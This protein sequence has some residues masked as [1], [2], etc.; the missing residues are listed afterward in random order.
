[1]MAVNV[2][3]SPSI[4]ENPEVKYSKIFRLY[5][6]NYTASLEREC[7]S[8][9]K[10]GFELTDKH[11]W[12]YAYR[13]HEHYHNYLSAVIHENAC[14]KDLTDSNY[15]TTIRDLTVSL[16]D[17]L[18]R[19]YNRETVPV[20]KFIVMTQR[21]LTSKPK[22]QG[23]ASKARNL[24]KF[25]AR[26]NLEAETKRLSQIL[27]VETPDTISPETHDVRES[28]TE[29]EISLEGLHIGETPREERN[30]ND[31][32]YSA[33]GARVTSWCS[34]YK[35]PVYPQ[36]RKKVDG[37]PPHKHGMIP[38]VIYV[39][40]YTNS[41]SQ[42]SSSSRFTEHTDNIMCHQWRN[43]WFTNH[44]P[45]TTFGKLAVTLL[46][47]NKELVRR[48]APETLTAE[49]RRIR[50]AVKSKS[51]IIVKTDAVPPWSDD[52]YRKILSSVNSKDMMAVLRDIVS[53]PLG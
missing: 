4:K 50:R 38:L 34:M 35:I 15:I 9:L 30:D 10:F 49:Q 6:S 48:C 51:S 32:S 26:K 43:I 16:R 12:L 37:P 46:P 36:I 23:K 2:P 41:K 7:S 18:E 27:P 40:G 21:G 13:T 3:G 45:F 25:L 29:P 42:M 22:R 19:L 1:M 44:Y 39:P 47:S 17:K 8:D 5:L 24:E 52:D 14:V 53:R 33:I 31:V 28:V 20:Q 11:T